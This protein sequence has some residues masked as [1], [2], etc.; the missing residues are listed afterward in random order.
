[1]WLIIPIFDFFFKV[2]QKSFQGDSSVKNG[3][4]TSEIVPVLDGAETATPREHRTEAIHQMDPQHDGQIMHKETD[5][6]CSQ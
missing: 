1:M 6:P 4:C 5:L 2:A 3:H